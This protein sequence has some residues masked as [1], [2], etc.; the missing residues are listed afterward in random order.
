MQSMR[1]RQT[2]LEFWLCFLCQRGVG[3]EV[4]KGLVELT[5]II[6]LFTLL[7][8]TVYRRKTLLLFLAPRLHLVFLHVFL[9]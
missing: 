2:K 7:N 5:L 4:K 9:Q 8:L 1:T 6:E 3:G